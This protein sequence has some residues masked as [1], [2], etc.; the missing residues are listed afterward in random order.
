MQ[1]N[2]SNPTSNRLSDRNIYQGSLQPRGFPSLP[3]DWTSDWETFPSSDGSLQLFS[4]LHH[5]KDW[6]G[7]RT[8]VVLHGLGEHSG[9]YLHFPHFTHSAVDAVYGLDHRGHGRSEGARGHVDRFDLYADDVALAIARLHETLKKRFGHSEI[10]ALGHSMGGLILL[11]SLFL[12]PSLPI[13]SVSVSAPL[14]RIKANVPVVK[15]TAALVLSRV[16]GSLHMTSELNPNHLSHDKEVVETYVKDRLVHKKLTPRFF[17]E[18]LAAMEDTLKRDSGISLPL[19][20]LIPLQDEIVDPEAGLQFYRGLKNRV[21]L[22]K[23]YP[24]FFHEP[25]NEI[26][27]EQVFEDVVSWIKT[28][29][30]S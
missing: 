23:T 15:K 12:H 25:F 21:K 13:H 10:H 24:G 18:L 22:V 2:L 3:E 4:V 27:K 28:H 8:L 9:R 1:D 16:W 20:M 17:T 19:Q 14:L 26:G 11:R 30:V 7:K 5:K 29:A 6:K